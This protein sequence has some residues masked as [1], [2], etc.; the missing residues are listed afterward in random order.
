M[1]DLYT[2]ERR[3]ISGGGSIE[4]VYEI[5]T[6]ERITDSGSFIGGKT[7]KTVKDRKA[8]ERFCCRKGLRSLGMRDQST[9]VWVSKN[10]WK[11]DTTP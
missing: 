9:E 2:I 7:V 11:E 3:K 6:Y 8:A 10:L 4:T 5:R 1:K